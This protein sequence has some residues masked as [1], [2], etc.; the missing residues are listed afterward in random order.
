MRNNL[1]SA[2]G[3]GLR[4][5]FR[6]AAAKRENNLRPA[7]AI[8]AFVVVGLALLVFVVPILITL[9]VAAMVAVTVYGAL[10]VGARGAMR[11][12]PGAKSFRRSPL[13]RR[14]AIATGRGR[15]GT[16]QLMLDVEG[17][18]TI[19]GL[20]KELGH[21]FGLDLPVGGFA[22]GEVLGTG[23]SGCEFTQVDS[24]RWGLDGICL[25]LRGQRVCT[26]SIGAGHEGRD[27]PPD[28][29]SAGLQVKYSTCALTLDLFG[30]KGDGL[31]CPEYSRR[32]G[33]VG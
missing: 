5:A 6:M 17:V 32:K 4:D 14:D 20:S 8:V 19:G 28:E 24:Q 16:E 26:L 29:A 2:Y 18:A 15:S 9:L 22:A 3:E 1:G 13:P 27:W 21:R 12:S 25:F 11:L 10:E 23:K 31:M 7:L 30:I 33:E